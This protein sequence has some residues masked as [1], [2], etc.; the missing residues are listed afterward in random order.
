MLVFYGVMLGMFLAALDQT[1]VAT[2]LPRI[3]TDLQ[4]FEHMSWVVTAYL[5][6]STV[7]V[8]LCGKL[9]DLFGRRKLFIFSIVLFLIGSALSGLS[10]NMS[11]LILF[12]GIQGLGAG[13]I[14]PVAITVIGD[15]FSPRERGRYQG[16][17]GAVFATSSIVGP[18]LGGYLTDQASWRWIFYINLP[19][20]AVALFV[21]ATTMH[22]PF[23]RREHRVDYLGAGLLAAGATSV[24]MVAV[25]GGTTYPWSSPEIIGLS[26][27][28]AA[29]LAAF[30]F[31][32]R[33]VPEP[34]LPLGLF[35]IGIFTVSNVALLLVGAAMFGVIIYIPLFVQGVL[36]ATAT[37]SGVVLIPLMLAVVVA[38]VAS[39][40]IVTHT[41]RY[42]VFPISGTLTALVGFWL[43]TRLNVGSTRLDT[44]IAMVVVGLGIG[45]IMQTY[46]LAV[47]N[48]VPR[49]EL[50]VATA[51]TQFFRSM[52]GAF[53]VAV[54]GSI[55]LNRL[56]AELATRLGLRAGRLD[57]EAL[58]QPG[59]HI[60]ARTMD[61]V[62]E[63]LASG[64][65]VVFMAG[66]PV[67]GLALV[68]A[69]LLK[70]VPLR[71]VSYV[72]ASR[73]AAAA[74]QAASLGAEALSAAGADARQGSRS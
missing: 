47:Q 45:Q 27:A 44:T 18:L 57:P 61:A 3:V 11:Q 66:L 42:R 59:R 53:G 69:F 30:V 65:H 16:Y 71:S 21:I 19:I 58:L 63:G 34:V 74:G 54:M 14:L 9:S 13:G 48:A 41:G 70:E 55:L 28:G 49:T 38:V 8:P 51:S 32:E 5:L 62:R 7:S 4:G 36:G 39:G 24:L 35:R 64:L 12:R 46:T 31:V 1:I 2:A 6:A 73:D 60:P 52:G 17:T 72:S 33:R 22:I 68:C 20:G 25:W 37:N 29:L 56:T 67:M 50:G 10:Q 15:L 26:V 40:R 23:H 43:L